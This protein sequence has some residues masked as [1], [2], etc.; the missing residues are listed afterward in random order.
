MAT[1]SNN[2]TIF[3]H[4]LIQHKVAII[5]DVKTGPKEFRELLN[6][7]ASLM[8]FEA[9]RELDTEAIKVETPLGTADGVRIS[10]KKMA[11]VPILRA[12]LGMV[13]AALKL[14]PVAKVGHIGLYRD[15]ETC[16]PVRYYCKM[17]EDIKDR[18][19]YIVDPML[20][21]G[22]SVKASID[23]LMNEY[24]CSEHRIKVLCLIGC[25]AGAK[26]VHDAHPGVHIY[27]A[28]MDQILD[29]RNYI[30]PGLGDAGDRI[31]GTK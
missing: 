26:V 21:T 8:L 16:K 2:L 1:E 19:V 10:G 30:V 9:T 3:T 11:F 23:I 4:P 31:Y 27:M 22:G 15:H 14:I 29:E 17:P 18:D 13:D 24:G 6:E 12:G 5:R 28:Q 25:P 7:I 20:A